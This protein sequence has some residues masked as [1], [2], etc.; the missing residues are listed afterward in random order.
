MIQ[1]GE[2]ASW[3]AVDTIWLR[4]WLSVLLTFYIY[5]PIRFNAVDQSDS[6]MSTVVMHPSQK[7]VQE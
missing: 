2:S 1:S 6:S 5:S 4:I 7:Y 3:R